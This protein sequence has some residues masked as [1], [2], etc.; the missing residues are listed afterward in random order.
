MFEKLKEWHDDRLIFSLRKKLDKHWAIVKDY[1][2]IT[3]DPDASYDEKRA[4]YWNAQEFTEKQ[5]DFM[6]RP[7]MLASKYAYFDALV[8]GIFFALLIVSA[9]YNT[10]LTVFT[11][12][13]VY[14]LLAVIGTLS[15]S[16]VEHRRKLRHVVEN[17]YIR[18]MTYSLYS[19]P[20][21]TKWLT[22]VPEDV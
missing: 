6:D 14:S 17:Q 2:K 8:P 20:E 1:I 10:V 18:E 22:R 9:G 19:N 4:A 15:L 3:C 7:K 16:L 11:M 13:V 21:R 5:F 12:T